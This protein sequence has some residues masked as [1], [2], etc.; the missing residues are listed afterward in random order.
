MGDRRPAKAGRHLA[1]KVQ[2]DQ[3]YLQTDQGR[4]WQSDARAVEHVNLISLGREICTASA[5]R[6]QACLIGRLC[7]RG[8]AA[9]A[10]QA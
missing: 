4:L 6:C 3:D 8:G 10:V 9:A 5:P 1:N 7:L 2:R